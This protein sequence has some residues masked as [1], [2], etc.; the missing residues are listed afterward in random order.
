MK[1]LMCRRHYILT[2]IA[3]LNAGFW[4]KIYRAVAGREVVDLV[5]WDL[6]GCGGGGWSKILAAFQ[7]G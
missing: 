4:E 2:H 5:T 3:L 7:R 6:I 1:W